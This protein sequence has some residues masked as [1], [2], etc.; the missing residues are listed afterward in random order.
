MIRL[1]ATSDSH[2]G[3]GRSALDPSTGLNAA[4]LDR[5]RVLKWVVEDAIG[6]GAQCILHAGDVWER[7]NPNPTEVRLVRDALQPAYDAGVP[8]VAIVGNHDQPRNGNDKHALDLLRDDLGTLHVI[9]R[10]CI[11]NVWQHQCGEMDGE[12]HSYWNGDHYY[13][14]LPA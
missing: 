14:V 12:G 6:R 11:L 3:T 1:A 13:S 7:W 5:A 9:D 2:V 4:L 10:P 8:V